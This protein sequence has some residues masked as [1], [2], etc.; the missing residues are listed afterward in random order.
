MRNSIKITL[1][2][3]FTA[4]TMISAAAST[5]AW[6]STT[7]GI[8]IDDNLT[9]ESNGAYFADGDGS[10]ERPFIINRPVHLYNLA[11]LQYLGYFNNNTIGAA[12]GPTY[13]EIDENLEGSLDMDGWYLP[14]IGTTLNPFVGI[15]NGNG[16]TVANLTTINS[17]SPATYKKSP[18]P[19]RQA[20]VVSNVNVLGMFG[21][22]GECELTGT[23]VTSLYPEAGYEGNQI[24]DFYIDNGHVENYQ[25]S[26]IAGIAA[27]YVNAPLSGVGISTTDTGTPSSIDLTKASNPTVYGGKTNISDFTSIGYCEDEYK[28]TVLDEYVELYDPSS[29][30]ALSGFVA[31][32]TGENAGWGGS[33]DMKTMYNGLLQS[34]NT[35]SNN[36]T[37]IPEYP[38]T[39]TITYD[40]DNNLVSDVYGG[41]T[42]MATFSSDYKYFQYEQKSGDY[43]TSSYTFAHRTGTSS[44]MYLYG[45]TTNTVSNALTTTTNGYTDEY[46][47]IISYTNG[48]TTYYLVANG[49][50]ISQTQNA[51]DATPTFYDSTNKTLYYCIN[52]VKY[53]IN[54]NN[55]ATLNTSANQNQATQWN[56]DSTAGTY[57]YT[58]NNQEYYIYCDGTWKIGLDNNATYTISNGTNY[59]T[60]TTTTTGNTNQASSATKFYYDN[61]YGFYILQGSTR[62]YVSISCKR[63]SWTSYTYSLVMNQGNPVTETSRPTTNGETKTYALTSSSTQTG[64]VTISHVINNSTYYLRYNSGDRKSVV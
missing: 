54:Q 49:T 55:R 56:Y 21:V 11:W 64:T 22:V 61:T 19:V 63:N 6:F 58:Y 50:T 12:S 29:S 41:Y 9:G 46:G 30:Q 4:F 28:E 42:D 7:L 47:D 59:L 14:P 45:D 37:G 3:A 62:Y 36:S 25:S 34:W 38:T 18:Y 32:D 23:G 2:S 60:A 5:I 48:T 57:S 13:F 39:R 1:I 24:S 27:G 53:Y 31:Q 44:Y 20:N 51:A 33:I 40:M 10:E 43:I 16:K 8:E 17:S 26:T 52:G 35:Y 15:F